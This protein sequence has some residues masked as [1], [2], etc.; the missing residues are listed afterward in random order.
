[1]FKKQLR[2]SEV[3]R[4]LIKGWQSQPGLINRV[5]AGGDK[6]C[7]SRTSL[8][9]LSIHQFRMLRSVQDLI[10]EAMILSDLYLIGPS[11]HINCNRAS[12]PV[13]YKRDKAAGCFLKLNFEVEV[14]Y[15]LL[16]DQSLKGLVLHHLSTQDSRQPPVNKISLLDMIFIII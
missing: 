10:T 7:L 13:K 4:L 15:V 2:Y 8:R 12:I 3:T 5:K 6:C 9:G 14:L 1:M 11:L 16:G